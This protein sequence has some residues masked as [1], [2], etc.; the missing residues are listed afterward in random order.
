MSTGSV[1]RLFRITALSAACLAL[2]L[3][4]PAQP[5]EDLASLAGLLRNKQAIALQL[6]GPIARCVAR[7]DTSHAAFH[8]C[9]DWHSAAHGTWALIAYANATGDK[10]YLPL[11]ESISRLG[12]CG[13]GK[14]LHPVSP[15]FR[16]ALWQGV[17]PQAGHRVP[18]EVPDERPEALRRRGR[19]VPA[20][21]LPGRPPGPY[22]RSY[23]SAAWALINLLDYFSTERDAAGAAAV[24]RL[25]EERFVPHQ[26]SC[27]LERESRTFMAICTNWAWLVSKVLPRPAFL[28]W[29]KGFLPRRAAIEPVVVPRTA[30]E[31]GLNFS[32]AWGLWGLYEA[33]GDR[34]F[35]ELFAR[36]FLTTFETQDNWDGDYRTVAHWVAQ[37]GMFAILP[38]FA[39][40]LR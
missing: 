19:R 9:I 8:G 30:H 28:T 15:L 10:R 7:R 24:S 11:V 40:T 16:D 32:R 38:L 36:H 34:V 37:F 18:A 4:R 21:S 13:G 12:Q 22:A 27:R 6:S 26:G 25:V 3:A 33:T 17:V 29:L 5:S 35:A 1:E 20:R 39:D 2:L 31:F 23:D 14:T